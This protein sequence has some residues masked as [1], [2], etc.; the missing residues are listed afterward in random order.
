[1]WL[2]R[3]F[4]NWLFSSVEETLILRIEELEKRVL[5]LESSKP[6]IV[7][8]VEA[9]PKSKSMPRPFSTSRTTVNR[10]RKQVARDEIGRAKELEAHVDNMAKYWKDKNEKKVV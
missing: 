5:D 2:K 6:L 3:Q 7:E 10:L 4:V 8:A 9:E 1:M